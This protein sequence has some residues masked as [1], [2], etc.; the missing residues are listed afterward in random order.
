MKDKATVEVEIGHTN[1]LG[2]EGDMEEM[3]NLK[4][5]LLL[6]SNQY[7]MTASLTLKQP[8]HDSTESN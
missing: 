7:A 3:T 4:I 1:D 6:K 8:M 2:V 5:L